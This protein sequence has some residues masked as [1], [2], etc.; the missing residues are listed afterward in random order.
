MGTRESLGLAEP[1]RLKITRSSLRE[2][3][4]YR[5]KGKVIGEDPFP[6]QTSSGFYIHMHRCT[7]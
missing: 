7:L 4:P 1:V 2:I 5:N 3:M 6:K